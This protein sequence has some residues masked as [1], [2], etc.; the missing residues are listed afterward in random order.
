MTAVLDVMFMF[1]SFHVCKNMSINK[2]K[3]TL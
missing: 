3:K 1:L 2:E